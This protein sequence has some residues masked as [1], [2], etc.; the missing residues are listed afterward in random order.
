MIELLPIAVDDSMLRRVGRGDHVLLTST[1]AARLW[2]DLRRRLPAPAGYITV[3]E[4]SAALLRASDPGV[5]VVATAGSG[6]ELACG[7]LSGVRRV[8][9]PCSTERRDETVEALT[10]RGMHLMEFPLYAPVRPAGAGESLRKALDRQKGRITI[11]FFSPSA[12]RNCFSLRPG[13]R[14]DTIFGAIG[15]TTATAIR[16]EGIAEVARAAEP[17]AGALADALLAAWKKG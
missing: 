5:P 14:G 8:L 10:G 17:R 16:A 1:F 9:Y 13:F 3:G 11:A 12:V 4:R 7:D 6:A 15:G 2:L